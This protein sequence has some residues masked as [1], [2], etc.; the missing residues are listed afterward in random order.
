MTAFHLCV[1]SEKIGVLKGACKPG[2]RAVKRGD[3]DCI[4]CKDTR[5]LCGSIDLDEW[6]RSRYS[7]QPRWDYCICYDERVY[8][9]EVHPAGGGQKVKE[10]LAKKAWTR[11][12]LKNEAAPILDREAPRQAWVWV[13]SGKIAMV[14]GRDRYSRQL[15]QSGIHGPVSRFT[16]P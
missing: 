9:I 12:W 6:L 4:E 15:A 5:K 10:V 2:I 1:V 14:P 11:K 3:R 7:Q 13:A 16:L 8:F